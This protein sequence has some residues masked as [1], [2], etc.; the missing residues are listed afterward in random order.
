MDWLT[1]FSEI[2]KSLAWPICLL[3][4]VTVFHKHISNLI[5]RI[6]KIDK[7]GITAISISE[8]QLEKPK[9]EAVHLLLDVVSKSVVI[10]SIEE[11]IK[12]DLMGKGLETTGNTIDVL[13][14]HLAGTSL[15]LSFVQIHSQIFGSQLIL[16]NKLNEMVGQGRSVAFINDYFDHIKLSFPEAFDEWSVDQYLNYMF[17]NLLITQNENKIHITNKGVEY[18]TWIARNGIQDNKPL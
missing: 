16:L 18:L 13:I 12:N 1:F 11:D 2:S 7:E 15:L 3:I 14:R 6:V 5:Q 9:P 4:L 10:A 8:M 17:V